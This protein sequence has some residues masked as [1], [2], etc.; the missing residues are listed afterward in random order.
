MNPLQSKLIHDLVQSVRI[1]PN[2]VKS[3]R[4][5]TSPLQSNPM[6]FTRVIQSKWN[7]FYSNPVQSIWICYL[8]EP[9]LVQSN[10][11]NRICN[12]NESKWIQPN[13]IELATLG[14]LI[15]FNP[16]E[17]DRIQSNPTEPA[18]SRNLIWFN[19]TNS[20]QS[21][22]ICNFNES[23]P[24]QSVQSN[25]IQLNPIELATL[26][27]LIWFN[28]IEFDRIQS[29][30]TES[31][32]SRNLIWFNLT[33]S[34]QPGRICNINESNPSQSVQSNRIQLNPIE[35]NRFC[36][37]LRLTSV[38][39]NESNAIRWSGGEFNSIN[40]NPA[41]SNQLQV[42]PEANNYNPTGSHSNLSQSNLI[43]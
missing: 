14:N 29:N 13:P 2:P 6:N 16:I 30:P 25:Q 20:I 4:I 19:L 15:W 17:F 35:S 3:S 12:F 43:Q 28:P 26:E 10:E 7:H 5:K 42:N 21:G 36:N 22:R 33:N 31:A 34:I 32:I 39:P 41:Q 24:S 1:Q 38:Q 23:N 40:C 9:S 18:I 11:S 27:N 37:L 8:N